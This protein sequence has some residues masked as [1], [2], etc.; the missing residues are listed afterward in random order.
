MVR[1]VIILFSITI[2]IIS[3]NLYASSINLEYK[4]EGFVGKFYPQES[5][6]EKI[7][8]LVL[9]GAEGGIPFE[10]ASSI[11]E[12]GYPALAL[13]YFNAEGLPEE[14]EQIP[15]EYFSPAKS[16]LKSQQGI[17]SDKLIVVGWSKGAELALML[18]SRDEQISHV[19]A[20]A[21]SSV[22][23]AGILKDWTKV[24][25]SSWTE[26]GQDLVYVPFRPS[27]EV[28]GLHDLYSQ[29]LQ[30][31]HDSGKAD[32]PVEDIH[33]QVI[34]MSGGEDEIWPASQMAAAVC[35]KINAKT[36]GK[37]EHL[38]YKNSSHLLGEEFLQKNTDMNKT[39]VSKLKAANQAQR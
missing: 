12:A 25:A 24:P 13:A 26:N 31:R 17:S 5:N 4:K 38:N 2:S 3:C 8:V 18:A 39:F 35:N 1:K 14:L 33:A 23:W 16:W 9:G 32:I 7:G 21:P 30:N 10:L 37:C 34:L 36:P 28:K 6:E 20:I 29:S 15:L 22:V 19:I 27:G 11:A